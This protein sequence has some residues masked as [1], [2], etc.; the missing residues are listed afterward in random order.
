[1]IGGVVPTKTQ[2]LATAGVGSATKTLSRDPD[3]AWKSSGFVDV[4]DQF[5]KSDPNSPMP[6]WKEVY[7]LNLKPNPGP[8]PGPNPTL[9]LPRTLPRTLSNPS[10][11]PNPNICKA[12]IQPVADDKAAQ[13]AKE[14]TKTN[15]LKP[16]TWGSKD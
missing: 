13:S 2:Q 11:N 9:S 1:M 8:N 4:P 10:P 15:W 16:S 5:P 6:K 14:K 7:S 12:F 3:V